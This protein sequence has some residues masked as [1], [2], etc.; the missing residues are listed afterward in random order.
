VVALGRDEE[1]AYT[2]TFKVQGA[3]EVQLLV[4]WLFRRRG[5]LGLCP[6]GEKIGEDLGLDGLSWAELKVEFTQLDQLLDNAPHGV[7]GAQDFSEREA[8]ND[9]DLVRLKV[10]S[11]LARRNEESI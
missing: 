6:L 1:D 3:V 5:L 2:C 9:L 8:G 11:P 7:A 4:L 10:M